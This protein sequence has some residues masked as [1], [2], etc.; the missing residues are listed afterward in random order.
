MNPTQLRRY[1]KFQFH[2]VQLT[3]PRDHVYTYVT[4]QFQFHK[5]QLTQTLIHY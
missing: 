4:S 2:K 1:L 5:V 3:L